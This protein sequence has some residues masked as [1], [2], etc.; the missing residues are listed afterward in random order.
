MSPVLSIAKGYIGIVTNEPEPISE[1]RVNYS[2]ETAGN[3]IACPHLSSI[4]RHEGLH[5]SIR[6]L[7]NI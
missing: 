6:P 1:K 4:F 3:D 5:A 7:R 2:E